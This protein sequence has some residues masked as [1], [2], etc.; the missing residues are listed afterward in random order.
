MSSS[1]QFGGEARRR[2][3]PNTA[4]TEHVAGGDGA[5]QPYGESVTQGNESEKNPLYDASY[6]DDTGKAWGSKGFGAGPG[7]GGRRGLPPVKTRHP[8]NWKEWVVYHEEWVWT[9]VYTFLAM[10]TR[11]WKIGWADYVVWDEAHFGKFGS[12]Y[13]NRDF[14]FDVHPPLGKMLVGLAGLL[15]GY[16]GGF[17]FKSGEHYPETVP[18]T[19]MRVILATFGVGMVPVAWWTAGELGWSRQS[20]HLVTLCVLFDVGWLCISRFILLDSMLIFFTFTTV[21]GL[22]KFHNQ[23]HD[24]FGEEWWFWLSFTGL[25]IGCVCSV[26]WVGLFATALVGLYTIEDLWDKFGDLR[27]PKMTYLKHWI[28]RGLCLILTPFCV[29][30]L[31]FKLH[32][33]ILNRSGP[34]DAQ[35]SSLFQAHLRGNNFAE[36][37][38]EIAI[39]SKVSIKNFGY[40]GGLLHS[41][42][43]TFPVGSNQQQVTCYHYKDDNNNFIVS[44]TWEEGDYDPEAPLKFLQDGSVIRLVHASTGRNLHSHAIPAPMT[45]NHY[46]VAGYGNGTLGDTNDHWV[47]EVVDD[48]LA[49]KKSQVDRI[50]ALTTRMRFRHANLN[51]Y[52]RAANVPLPQWGFKQIEVTCDKENNPKDVHTYWN[53]ESHWNDR[54]PQ[55]NV[56]LYKS[57]FWKDFWHLNVAMMTSNNA[58]VPDPDKED[59]L[60]S[61]PLDWPFLHL[62]LRMCGWADNQIKYYLIG[63]PIIWWSSSISLIVGIF[64]LG[65]YLMRMQRQYQ[66]WAPGE[67]ENWLYVLKIAFGG[68]AFHYL[69]FLIMGRVTYLHHYLPTLWFAV[70][71]LGHMLETFIFSSR[72]RSDRTKWIWFG[73]LA[74]SIFL[75]FWWF[76]AVAIGI[77]GP[78]REHKGLGWRKSW[79]IYNAGE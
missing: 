10:L 47:V 69:P 61:A 31:S 64:T 52:L 7:K 28:A 4:G 77:S 38:L 68:W 73:I 2:A 51:C 16:N 33:M 50:H 29:Y 13:I 44:P 57:P 17:E 60:A 45:K 32:F 70:L 71:F 56:K 35:M 36:S 76:K 30:A 43:Q 19:A 40:G 75:C 42:V 1:I 18:Y 72:K 63:T 21:L 62:G 34:G 53:I 9:G 79:N 55:G 54:L 15:S 24:S 6:D 14:Y 3:G 37:P 8:T 25:S 78:I 20:R 5:Q 23:R 39:G 58:L 22:V 74:G 27:M 11:Y 49:G 65:F 59:I 41:H 12:H 48:M 66:D 26:K 46:E 67:W